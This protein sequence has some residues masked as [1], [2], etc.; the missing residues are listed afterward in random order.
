MADVPAV[1]VMRS[2][3]A[4]ALVLLA[5][6]LSGAATE[7]F[8]RRDP[9]RSSLSITCEPGRRLTLHA[10]QQD[11]ADASGGMG[12]FGGPAIACEVE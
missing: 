12:V 11:G 2:R 3:L 7:Y 6:F 8:T 1:A 4:L 9:E 5:T 10:R